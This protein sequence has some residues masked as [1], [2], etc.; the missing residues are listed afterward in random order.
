MTPAL[1]PLRFLRQDPHVPSLP[2]HGVQPPEVLV[3]PYTG[4]RFRNVFVDL[5]TTHHEIRRW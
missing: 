4:H 5:S 2:A 1:I 3:Y